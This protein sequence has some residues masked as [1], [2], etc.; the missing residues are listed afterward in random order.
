MALIVEDGSGTDPNANSYLSVDD[1]RSYAEARGVD[2]S[3]K[4]NPQVEVL[5]VKAMDVLENPNLN[6]KGEK[7]SDDQP[8]LW[9]RMGVWDVETPG[10]LTPSD[11]IPRLLEQALAALVMEQL[12]DTG[13]TRDVIKKRVGEIEIVYSSDTPKKSFIDANSNSKA[14]LAPLRE[15]SGFFQVVRA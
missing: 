9:P 5:I 8:L 15:R 3:Q 7:S 1:L 2:L 4:S 11:T 6:Y 14:L 13:D 12:N 10:K